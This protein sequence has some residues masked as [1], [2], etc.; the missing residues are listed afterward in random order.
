ML[1]RPRPGLGQTLP[2][3]QPASRCAPRRGGPQA[4]WAGGSSGRSS[5]TRSCRTAQARG[6]W[7]A[8]LPRQGW[9]AEPESL[10]SR[11][12]ARRPI[13]A[14]RTP[15]SRDQPARL[16]RS[17]HAAGLS[18]EGS[19]PDLRPKSQLE[20][21]LVVS[22]E[23]TGL[24]PAV[25]VKGCMAG[26]GGAKAPQHLGDEPAGQ[27]AAAVLGNGPH[28]ADDADWLWARIILVGLDLAH[29]DRGRK[30]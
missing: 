11:F 2:N 9:G 21:E 30:A 27:P 4:S 29:R 16:R 22:I 3:K 24:V 5:G 18:L 8:G 1:R 26:A 12:P 25:D 7:N 6:R 10:A 23:R 14:W 19:F 20:T 13:G 15:P 28:R 17:R